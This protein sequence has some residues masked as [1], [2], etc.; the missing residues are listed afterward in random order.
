MR[1]VDPAVLTTFRNKPRCE[2]CGRSTRTGAHPHHAYARGMGGGSHLDHEWNLLA[3]CAWCHR[4]V[5]DGNI[6]REAVW[7]AI[8][9]RDGIGWRRAQERVWELLRRQ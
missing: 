3:A 6:T 2:L 1:I 7:A 5:H 8:G 9:Q 4:L